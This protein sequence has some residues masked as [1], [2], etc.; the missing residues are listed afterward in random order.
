MPMPWHWVPL[1]RPDTNGSGQGLRPDFPADPSGHASFGS[2]AFQLRRLFLAEEGV[3]AF[4]ANGADDVRFDFVSDEFNG[5]NNDP[6][7]RRVAGGA[8]R[9]PDRARPRGVGR[10]RCRLG[11]E[12]NGAVPS[13]AARS[14]H[15]AQR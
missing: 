6:K 7:T 14:P 10:D 12:L 4:D 15:P 11:R 13:R 8:D 2:A 1:G 3:A 9:Q 5:H